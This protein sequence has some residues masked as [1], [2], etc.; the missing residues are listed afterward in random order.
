MDFLNFFH[1][2]L[3]V[4]AGWGGFGP[5]LDLTG[6]GDFW[7]GGLGDF[8]GSMFGLGLEERTSLSTVHGSVVVALAWFV[9]WSR[10]AAYGLGHQG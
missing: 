7:G 2:R 1:D 5:D 10:W 4:L 3:P 6:A 9:G 8:R